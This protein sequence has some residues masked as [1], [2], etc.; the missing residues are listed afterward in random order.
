MALL[1]DWL[2]PRGALGTALWGSLATLAAFGGLWS[3]HG[4]QDEVWPHRCAL[5]RA[6][7]AGQPL[8]EMIKT[9]TESALSERFMEAL[10]A[11]LAS[12]RLSLSDRSAEANQSNQAAQAPQLRLLLTAPEGGSLSAELYLPQAE[13][14]VRMDEALGVNFSPEG[15]PPRPTLA[16]L[17]RAGLSYTPSALTC[18]REFVTTERPLALSLLLK[19]SLSPKGSAPQ[20]YGLWG[21]LGW[22]ALWGEG[23]QRRARLWAPITH[24][25]LSGSIMVWTSSLAPQGSDHAESPS[26]QARAAL[27]QELERLLSASSIE[28]LLE[29]LSRL[30]PALSSDSAASQVREALSELISG[31]EAEP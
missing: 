30:S 28:G 29:D 2:D 24:G 13:A 19:Q 31:G 15:Y 12:L 16:E 9:G 26:A 18:T 6:Q 14:L 11:P 17:T 25:P 8:Y 10:Q 22:Y 20:A 7:M 3:V 23:A 1:S 4:H 27:P 21:G 5:L